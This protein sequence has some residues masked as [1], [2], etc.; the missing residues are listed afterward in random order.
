MRLPALNLENKINQTTISSKSFAAGNRSS[1]K[2]CN[3]GRSR[4]AA[5]FCGTGV[6]T[7]VWDHPRY[8]CIFCDSCVSGCVTGVFVSAHSLK[9]LL[10]V[11]ITLSD[12]QHDSYFMSHL[13]QLWEGRESPLVNGGGGAHKISSKTDILASWT[14]K[15]TVKGGEGVPLTDKHSGHLLV[16]GPVDR[17]HQQSDPTVW[18][19]WFSLSPTSWWRPRGVWKYISSGQPLGK[20][21]L[22]PSLFPLWEIAWIPAVFG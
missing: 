5:C 19:V 18:N 21:C 4:M 13:A 1:Y 7:C 10:D 22:P 15:G 2:S 9:C 8:V 17:K 14:W 12:L 20:P 16:F 3:E 11:F 6:S